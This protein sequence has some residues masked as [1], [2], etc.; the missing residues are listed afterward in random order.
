MAVSNLALGFP[1]DWLPAD[2]RA[3]QRTPQVFELLAIAPLLFLLSFLS[4]LSWFRYL[5][6]PLAS[7][8]GRKNVL[9]TNY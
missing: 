9:S 7:F 5:E 8:M 4:S 1:G 3:F 6:I 2:F